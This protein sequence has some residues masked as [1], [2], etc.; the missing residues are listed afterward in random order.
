MKTAN[1]L[2]IVLFLSTTLVTAKTP[3]VIL[4]TND[5]HSQLEPYPADDSRNPDGAGIVRREALYSQVRSEEPNVLVFDAGDL[6]QGTPYF[7]FF[8]GEAEVRLTNYLKPDAVTLGN[9][10]FDN[11]IDSLSKMLRKA[12]FSIVSTNYDVSRTSLKE[13][14][15]PWLVIKKG[16]LRI[17]VVGANINPEGLVTQ[18][19]YKGM[20]WLEPIS[21]VEARAAWLKCKKKCD[22]VICLSHLGLDNGDTAPDDLTLADESKSIDVIIGGHTHTFLKKPII[23]KNKNGNNVIINQ[24]GKGGIFVGRLDLMVGE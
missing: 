19:N 3:L 10:E 9:H 22:I 2:A 1:I 21:T 15:K 20:V 14:V 23:R 16:G 11:G 7:N 8:K 18:A 13:I 12:E 17:G 5:T 6:V 4:H 24:V